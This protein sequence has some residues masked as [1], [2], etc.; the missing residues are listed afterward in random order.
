MP[1]TTYDRKYKGVNSMFDEKNS[2][3][4]VRSEKVRTSDKY[5][6]YNIKDY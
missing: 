2:Q 3:S 1:N 4:E 6:K 5:K